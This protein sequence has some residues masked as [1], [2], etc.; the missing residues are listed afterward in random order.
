MY[1]I[2]GLEQMECMGSSECG[3]ILFQQRVL[4]WLKDELFGCFIIIIIQYSCTA[5]SYPFRIF[6]STP[7]C[8]QGNCGCPSGK[9]KCCMP[10][11]LNF[12]AE[13][14]KCL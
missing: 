11:P 7:V 1:G 13:F 12:S 5:A 10:N 4:E 8:G 14:L 9:K 3:I 6:A 2:Y